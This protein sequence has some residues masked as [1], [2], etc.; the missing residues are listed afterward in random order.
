MLPLLAPIL[1]TLA[2]SGLSILA[3]AIQAKGKSVIEDKLGIKIPDNADA[4]TPELLQQ[5]KLKEIEHEEF[6]IDA[7]IR[8]A[9]VDNASEAAAS[10]EVTKRWQSDMSSDNQLSKNVRPGV[11]IYLTAAMTLF[12]ILSIW[13]LRIDEVYVTLIGQLLMLVYGAYF[14]G[15]SVEKGLDMYH[16]TKRMQN[17]AD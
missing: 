1:T 11:L 15:R 17:G 9:E 12:A 2:S 10:E 13:G 4:L 7:Q 3:G 8:K 6:L 16:T 5:L 14:V